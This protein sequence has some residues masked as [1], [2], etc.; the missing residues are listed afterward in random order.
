[1]DKL[2]VGV[3]GVGYLGQYHAEKYAALPDVELVGVSD[4][5]PARAREVASRCGTRAF[6]SHKE[7]L[8]EV[9]AASIAVPTP[10]HFAVGQ[11]FLENG[12][13]LLMEKPIAETTEQ[14]QALVSMARSRGLILQVGHL[15][16][17]NPA[18]M[19]LDG[20]VERP[21][22]MEAHRLSTYKPRA[23]NVSVVLDLMIHD[24][25]IVMSLAK[26]PVQTIQATGSR[27]VSP[28]L[29]VANAR[30]AFQSGCVA[31]LTASRVSFSDQRKLRVYER[32][33]YASVDFANRVTNIMRPGD[34]QAQS[35]IPGMEVFTSRFEKADA[36]ATEIAAFVACARERK[37]PRVPGHK[38]AQALEAA[39]AIT[40]IIEE[41]H[42]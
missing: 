24:I 36:L 8:Q 23:L 18:L 31:S 33:R 1:M 6:A 2:R 16:R 39:L 15:E 26:S 30:I 42:A 37:E 5:D 11:D 29:D 12:V 4:T 13:D 9:S 21:F 27:V 22:F 14:A 7:L 34:S 19:A 20:V 41:S 10:F 38:A 32:D 28:L 3:V 35:A 17:F 40:R 25:E